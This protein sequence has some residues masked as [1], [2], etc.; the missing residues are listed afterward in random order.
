MPAASWF[1]RALLPWYREN[2]RDLPWRATTDPYRVWLSEVILQQTRV[3]QGLAYWHRF[4][5]RYP[6][7]K[8]LAAASEDEVLRLWQGL[9]YYSRARNLR[10]AAKQVV[11]A[12]GGSF[13]ADYT[14][15]KKLKGVGEYTAAAIGSICFGLPEPVVDGNVYRV[16]ARCFGVAT[17]IDSLA[18]RREFRELA[19]KLLDPTAPG[20]HNQAVMELGAT[21]CTPKNP[22]CDDCPLKRKCIARVSKRIGALPV[23]DKKAKVRNRYFNYLHVEVNGR[24]Y[25]TKRSAKD[26]WQGL[27]ELPLI[28]SRKALTACSMEAELGR[29][30]TSLGRPVR[31]KH[32]L[33]HQVLHAT[34]WRMKVPAGARRPTHWIAVPAGAIERYALP[35]LI[36][37][38]LAQAAGKRP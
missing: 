8:K 35:R 19:A 27:Y 32:I 15:L 33:S 17:P 9:G 3:D 18:G 5:K 31:M 24:T 1:S 6:T 36:E 23:K 25:F 30:W 11:R 14:T 4:V 34:F 29:G 2:R 10:V 38:Y 20:D 28:E 12:H 22:R 21:V 37:R 13:P 16:L 7:V 26:I